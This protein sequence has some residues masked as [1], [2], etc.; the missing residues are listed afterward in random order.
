[1]SHS[2]VNMAPQPILSENHGLKKQTNI[3]TAKKL[4]S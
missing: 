2:L 4:N 1:M 3:Q